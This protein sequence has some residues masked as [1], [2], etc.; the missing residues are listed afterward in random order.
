MTS[1]LVRPTQFMPLINPNVSGPPPHAMAVEWKPE[2]YPTGRT[3][4]KLCSP[5]R[6]LGV[7]HRY[8]SACH[9]QYCKH[10]LSPRSPQ[11]QEAT[12]L[13]PL[14]I[15]WESISSSNEHFQSHNACH[16]S[17]YKRA[18]LAPPAG[19]C[20]G[21]PSCCDC[22]IGINQ[23]VTFNTANMPSLSRPNPQAESCPGSFQQLDNHP[24]A[25][26]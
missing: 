1:I 13:I 25:L 18:S 3:S 2:A 20:R 21:H 11:R 15:P 4:R 16:L 6:L 26:L 23:R 17:N 10:A 19:G 12:M 24:S 14:G 5:S 9:F 7:H 22:N 8:K